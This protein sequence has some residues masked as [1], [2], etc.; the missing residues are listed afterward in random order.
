MLEYL[1]KWNEESLIEDYAQMRRE[2]EDAVLDL[3]DADR[4]H[5]ID[6]RTE[7]MNREKVETPALELL[8]VRLELEVIG[9]IPT[10][11]DDALPPDPPWLLPWN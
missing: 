10:R 1:I 8:R 5:E 7:G 11:I 2:R 6:R 4:E 3:V 9:Q